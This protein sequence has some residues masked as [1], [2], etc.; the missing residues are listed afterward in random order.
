M[1]NL[2][3]I[4]EKHDCHQGQSCFFRNIASKLRDNDDKD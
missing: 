2:L 1:Q 3:N 4:E